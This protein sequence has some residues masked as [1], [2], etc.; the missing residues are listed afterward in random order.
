MGHH[1]K[2]PNNIYGTP[3]CDYVIF[4]GALAFK[5]L[6]LKNLGSSSMTNIFTAENIEET[7]K[8]DEKTNDIFYK[9]SLRTPFR[10]HDEYEGLLAQD[11]TDLTDSNGSYITFEYHLNN[12]T[13]NNIIF[14]QVENGN[15]E[16]RMYTDQELTRMLKEVPDH[17]LIAMMNKTIEMFNGTPA[18]E[19]Q[20]SENFETND[21]QMQ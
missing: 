21:K 5:R 10:Q 3:V 17:P 6:Q 18:K 13:F 19:I 7:I 16:I 4:P 12:G 9:K 2:K 20:T 11:S 15:T 1:Y 8:I 14:K